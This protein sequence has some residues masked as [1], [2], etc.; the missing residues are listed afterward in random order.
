MSHPCIFI[1]LAFPAFL[2]FLERR[3]RAKEAFKVTTHNQFGALEE[4]QVN[5]WTSGTIYITSTP[6]SLE[7]CPEYGIIERVVQRLPI[8]F[9]IRELGAEGP[10][11]AAQREG[12]TTILGPRLLGKTEKQVT[13]QGVPCTAPRVLILGRHSWPGGAAGP[14]GG[15]ENVAPDEGGEAYSR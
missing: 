12:A 3:R 4:I 5:T 9:E 14:D 11:V 13:A 2:A 1:L 6:T 15:R 10:G 7:F 8:L